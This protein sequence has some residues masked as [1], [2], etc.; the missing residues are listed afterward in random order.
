MLSLLAGTGG[1][2]AKEIAAIRSAQ[3]TIHLYAKLME[4]HHYLPRQFE[5]F[6]AQN[7]LNIEDYTGKVNA[8]LHRMMHGN[9]ANGPWK[10]GLLFDYNS[11]W[12]AW[13]K[14]NPNA[15][16]AQIQAFASQLAREFGLP[17]LDALKKMLR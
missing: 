4:T 17:E 8:L 15:S 6:F 14:A 1:L 11:R 16:R 7:G 12:G 13:I 10:R 5:R 2:A 3:Q 9:V